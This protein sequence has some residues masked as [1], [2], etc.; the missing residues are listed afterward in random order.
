MNGGNCVN[1]HSL[2]FLI[3]VCMRS[4]YSYQLLRWDDYSVSVAK[5]STSAFAHSCR[6][7]IWILN[8]KSE[9][10]HPGFENEFPW[11]ASLDQG[12]DIDVASVIVDF[13]N[14]IR[15]RHAPFPR[16]FRALTGTFERSVSLLDAH[17]LNI[18]IVDWDGHSKDRQ[19]IFPPKHRIWNASDR[20]GFRRHD[21][22][23]VILSS[24]EI[25]KLKL[26]RSK[27]LRR[28]L[29]MYHQTPNQITSRDRHR[30]GIVAWLKSDSQGRKQSLPIS[31]KFLIVNVHWSRPRSM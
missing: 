28:W 4:D 9:L 2:F 10:W 16:S 15:L 25:P 22:L 7:W 21:F 30:L 8:P 1:L 5:D 14:W 23:I 12:S 13:C 24:P 31:T 19:H 29:T 20:I 17:I 27:I 18:L 26:F 11:V 3:I 6:Q